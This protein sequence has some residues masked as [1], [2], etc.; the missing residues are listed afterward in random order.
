[1]A[2]V[3]IQM[4]KPEQ[5]KGLALFNLGFR[6]FFLG[7]AV[8]AVLSIVSWIAVYTSYSTIQIS[9]IIPSQ[10]HAH[11]M[12]YGYGMAVVAGFL[13]TAFWKN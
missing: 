8:F 7:A 2:V 3:Q 1:M 12:L 10:W 9:N 11:E 13:L 6:P 5:V 4:N